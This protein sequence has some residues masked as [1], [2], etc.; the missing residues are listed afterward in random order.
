MNQSKPSIAL[1]RYA[2][3]T[4]EYKMPSAED[5]IER[6]KSKLVSEVISRIRLKEKRYQ[7]FDKRQG[8]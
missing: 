1:Y 3:S 4:G 5:L 2:I 6:G 7:A 8:K